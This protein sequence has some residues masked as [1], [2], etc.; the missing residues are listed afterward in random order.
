[1][2]KLGEE[3]ISE[4]KSQIKGKFS[5]QQCLV[6]VSLGGQQLADF[7]ALCVVLLSLFL[8]KIDQN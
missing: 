7:P 5:A 3:K 4:K 8:T 1:M 2:H 6:N